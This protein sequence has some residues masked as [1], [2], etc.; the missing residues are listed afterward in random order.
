MPIFRMTM[1][2]ERNAPHPGSG[3]G[4]GGLSLLSV[5]LAVLAGALLTALAVGYDL[6]QSRRDAER[7]L[8]WR[9]DNEAGRFQRS[10]DRSQEVVDALASF[11]TASRDVGQDEFRRFVH[12]PLQ[13]HPEFHAL[14]WLPR[15]TQAQRLRTRAHPSAARS[16]HHRARRRRPLGPCRRAAGVF[17]HTLRGAP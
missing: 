16:G 9:A 12:N 8:A 2:S 10:L 7:Q 4:P 13:R 17:P 15:V 14:Q 5:L 6:H 3:T 1:T 11:M